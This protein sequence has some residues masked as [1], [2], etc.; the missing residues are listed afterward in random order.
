MEFYVHVLIFTIVFGLVKAIV[1]LT[2]CK[3]V[4]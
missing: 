3:T 1:K 2:G 4:A